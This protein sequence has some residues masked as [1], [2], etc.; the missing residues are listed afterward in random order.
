MEEA[1]PY[2]RQVNFPSSNTYTGTTTIGGPSSPGAT[3][4]I[5]ANAS[6]GNSGNNVVIQSTIS[7]PAILQ[8]GANITSPAISYPIA[9]TAN[10]TFDSNNFS[11]TIDSVISDGSSPGTLIKINPGT[12]TLTNSANSYTNASIIEEGTL[13][14][15]GPN[16]G[17]G[18]VTIINAGILQGTQTFTL[19]NSPISLDSGGIGSSVDVTTAQELTLS[20]TLQNVGMSTGSLTKTG[21]GTL[22]LIGTNAYTAGTFITAGILQAG[23]NAALGGSPTPGVTVDAGASLQLAN[24]ISIPSTQVLAISGTGANGMGALTQSVN[25]SSSYA[26]QITLNGNAQIGTNGTGI[27]TLTGGIVK[28]GTTLTVTGGTTGTIQINSTGISGPTNFTSDLIV[29]GVILSISV[30]ST[31]AGPTSIIDGGTILANVLDALPASPRTTISLDLSGTGSSILTLNTDQAIQS[32]A[33]ASTSVVNLNANTL[34]IGTTSGTTTFAGTFSGLG[35]SITKEGG[36]TQILSGATSSNTGPTTVNGGILQ[37]GATN[38]FPDSAVVMADTAGAILDLHGFSQAIASLSG[39]GSTGG[40]VTLGGAGLTI[41]GGA[42]TTYA[43]SISGNGSLLKIGSSVLT[44]TG[45]NTYVGPTTIVEGTISVGQSNA[46]GSGPLTLNALG[47][48]QGTG[49]L[50]LPNTPIS[51]DAGSTIDVTALQDMT[52]SGNIQSGSLTKTGA[53]ILTLSG[54]NSYAGAT[55]VQAGTLQA[56]KVNAFSHQSAVVMANISG[57]ILD[58]NGFSQ[59]IPSL[60]GGGSMGGNVTLGGATL[61]I[62]GASST[63]YAGSIGGGGNLI[64]NGSGTLTLLGTNLYG[65]STD[66]LGGN[67]VVNGPLTSNPVRVGVS[68]ILSGNSTITG[69]VTNDG[70]VSPG[71]SIGTLTVTGNYIQA[72]GSTLLIEVDPSTSDLLAIS[73]TASIQPNATLQIELDP[74]RYSATNSYLI[75]SSGG[76]TGT[77]TNVPND[78]LFFLYQ[79]RYDADDVFLDVIMKDIASISCGGNIG[80]IATYLDANTSPIGSDFDLVIQLLTSLNQKDAVDQALA[81]LTPAPYKNFILAQEENVF[82]INR[83]MTDHLNTLF[84]TCCRR[85]VK[86]ERHCEVWSTIFGDFAKLNNRSNKECPIDPFLGYRAKGGGV[87]IGTDYAF[88]DTC[89]LGLTGAY[90]YSDVQVNAARAQGHINTV[91]GALYAMIYSHHF[92]LDAV[93]TGGFDY[94]DASRKIQ[95]SSPGVGSISRRAHTAHNGWQIDGHI[96]GG[97]VIDQWKKMEI[98]PFFAFD[99]LFLH[100]NRYQ[101]HGAH[102][103]NLQVQGTNNTLLRSEAGLNVSRCFTQSYGKWIPQLRASAVWESF[104]SNADS[105]RFSFANQPGSLVVKNPNPNRTCFSPGAGVAGVFFQDRML[106]SLDYNGEFGDGYQNQV[107]KAEFSWMF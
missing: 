56:G 92:F 101:E 82:S 25:G 78:L 76:L 65:G 31:Y 73:G 47:I 3:L 88:T 6:L 39:G 70:T 28:D 72:S 91:Y 80:E 7:Q 26:G 94:F 9:L 11:M 24:G 8:A 44:L 40:N 16:L 37:S 104:C 14:I 5:L 93:C 51:L 35:G 106:L 84:N 77:F 67:L 62:D 33:S 58:L 60:S 99:Y 53:G 107:G 64:K 83:G 69:N 32:L 71:N 18:P 66:V 38:A 17:T 74:G 97:Y 34:T 41:G 86:R 59:T 42:S 29:D 36:S 68:G 21:A 103:L 49:I 1:S 13:S 19:S 15:N 54:D 85:D 12:L 2:I 102:S 79:V 63:S 95:F 75:L 20:G 4:N 100:E 87:L 55:M 90:S 46:L 98:R 48:L 30:A 61:T 45:S 22:T 10:G 52:L 23:S 50:T 96:D 81:Q 105:Y 43:G 27:L 57:A 89:V